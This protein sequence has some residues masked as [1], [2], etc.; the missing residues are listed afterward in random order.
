MATANDLINVINASKQLP[1]PKT[2][3]TYRDVKLGRHQF[4][5]IRQGRCLEDQRYFEER[6][7]ECSKINTKV[8]SKLL[9]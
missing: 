5:V 6:K 7:E 8:L 2:C 9:A 3:A 1:H 4:G